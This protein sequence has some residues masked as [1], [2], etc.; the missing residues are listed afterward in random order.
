MSPDPIVGA[1]FESFWLGRRV[2]SLW[3]RYWWRPNQAHNGYLETYLNL[4]AIGVL[5]L[6]GL[7]VRGYRN[8]IATL[9]Q[10]PEAGRLKLAFL[11]A[12]LLYNLTEAAFKTTHPVWIAFFLAVIRVPRPAPAVALESPAPEDELQPASSPSY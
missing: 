4:G 1:G 12:A 10:D 6:G 9:Y 5:L 11:A 8:V 7:I 3:E 2:T